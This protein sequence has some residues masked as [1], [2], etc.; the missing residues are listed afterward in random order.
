MV[1]SSS[2]DGRSV[3]WVVIHTAEG[4]RKAADLRA[5]FERSSIASVHA[6]AD[7]YTL[8]DNL[9]S[10]SR[11]AWTLR[12]GNKVSDNLELCG[13]AKWSREEWL[14]NHKGMLDNA[15]AWIKS[16]CLARGIPVRKLDAAGVRRGDAGVIGH[17]DYTNGT[18]DGTHWDPGPGFP[19]D[20]VIAKASGATPSSPTTQPLHDDEEW[21]MRLYAGDH[22]SLSFDI[23]PGATTIRINCPM[24][25][26]TVHGIWQAGDG[27]PS[28]T[29]FDYKWSHEADFRVD[30]LRPWRINVAP[31]ATQGSLIYTYG[32]G[33]PERSG[34]LSFR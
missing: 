24:E 22:Q 5:Y 10:Y 26:L 2:R 21:N 33:H 32:V 16:R 19:W 13:F 31:G 28:G 4:I 7:D 15:A 12:N 20:Y 27:L 3:K 23:P 11:A 34:S 8:L 9:V 6:I 25:F 17:V 30:R 14:N 1:N 29:N 18:G